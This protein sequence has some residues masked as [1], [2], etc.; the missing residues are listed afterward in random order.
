MNPNSNEGYVHVER[1]GSISHIEFFHP[2]SNSLPSAV[3]AD[4]AQA[5][6]NEGQ[7]AMYKSIEQRKA[8]CGVR[9]MEPLARALKGQI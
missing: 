1:R 2:Q 7:D 8:C 6:R 3:L 9:K 5:I 4:L